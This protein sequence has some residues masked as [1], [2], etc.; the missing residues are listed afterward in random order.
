MTHL[1]KG[2]NQLDIDENLFKIV[3][4]LI[5]YFRFPILILFKPIYNKIEKN[6]AVYLAQSHKDLTKTASFV[7]AIIKGR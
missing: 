6:K 5:R 4:I 1:I 7:K 3:R 2:I